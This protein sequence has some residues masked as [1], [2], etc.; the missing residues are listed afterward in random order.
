ME[1]GHPHD[2]TAGESAF[3]GGRQ[4]SEATMQGTHGH[5]QE[6]QGDSQGIHGHT[7]ELHGNSQGT[8]EGR[9]P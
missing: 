6:L 2:R 5:P 4:R 9:S 8:A 1:P 7:E 3:E